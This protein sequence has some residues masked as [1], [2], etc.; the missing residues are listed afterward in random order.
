M[1]LPASSVLCLFDTAVDPSDSC[2]KRIADVLGA[3]TAFVFCDLSF[4]CTDFFPT[5]ETLLESGSLSGSE[6]ELEFPA[7]VELCD[8]SESLSLSSELLIEG[9]VWLDLV[10]ERDSDTDEGLVPSAS[11]AMAF[12]VGASSSDSESLSSPG[13]DSE[14]S[15]SVFGESM[16]I[17]VSERLKIE[18]NTYFQILT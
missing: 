15:D 6:A 18:E 5:S 8:D 11:I 13:E 17:T 14:E 16:G 2:G 4:T 7:D 9:R 10:G 1:E 3:L 12:G